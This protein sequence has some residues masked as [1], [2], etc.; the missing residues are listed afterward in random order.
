MSGDVSSI[1]LVAAQRHAG[2]QAITVADFLKR[3]IPPRALI[4]DPVL[5]EQGL[6]M[7][8]AQ[9]GIGKTH[10]A[11][12]MGY[13]IASGGSFLRWRAPRPRQVLFVDGEMPASAMQARIAAIVAGA[14][15][16]PPDPKYFRLITPDLLPID[17][18]IPNIAKRA[19]Q[20]MIDGA[21]E[22]ADVLILDNLSALARGLRENEADDWFPIQEWLLSLRRAGKSVVIIHHAGRAGSPRG[23]SKREDVLD[24]M[25]SLR[26][27]DGY[28][29]EEGA[30]F[31][32][33]L[34]KARGVHGLEARP[35]EARLETIDG[36]AKWTAR[37]IED[38]QEARVMTLSED[39]MSVREIATETGIPKS[40]VHRIVRRAALE[41]AR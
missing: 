17:V 37:D 20:E 7:L 38:E 10:V 15:Q 29:S 36:A 18:A 28:S 33:E 22:D 21:M 14:A 25:I 12:S 2:I 4:L 32:V 19:G 9:R 1:P 24:T 16:Q 5:P 23:T 35:F 31:I 3:P 41:S 8:F 11:L 27:P 26:R 39:G 30:R 13:A 40:T 6:A 34:T